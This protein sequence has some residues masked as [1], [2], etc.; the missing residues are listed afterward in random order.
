MNEQVVALILVKLF[1]V[2]G[3]VLLFLFAGEPDM[4]DVLIELVKSWAK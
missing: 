4:H 2:T 1:L 3:A